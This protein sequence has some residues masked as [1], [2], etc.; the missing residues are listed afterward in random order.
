MRHVSR[1]H[2]VALDWLFDRNNMDTKI[3]IKY[4][5]TKNQ[6]PDLLTK[7]NFTR[8]ERQLRRLFNIVNFS[9]CSCSHFLSH[10]K[11]SAMPKRTQER[12]TEEGPAVSKPRPACV[13]SRNLLSTRQTSFDSGA[14]NVPGNPELDSNSVSGSTGALGRD[15][16]QNPATSSQVWQKDDNPCQGTRRLVRSGVCERSGSI[17]KLVQGVNQLA[18]TT[19]YADLRQS[20]QGFREDTGHSFQMSNFLRPQMGSPVSSVTC[21]RRVVHIRSWRGKSHPVF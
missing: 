4:V 5:D 10:R 3:Q 14:S 6:L 13:V 15:R 16:V 17:G 1:T 12:R 8:D 18:R 20:V 11:Q 2:R 7:G 21:R 9:M 19:Q